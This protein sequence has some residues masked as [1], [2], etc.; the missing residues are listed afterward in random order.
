M[1]FDKFG[2]PIR[3]G[4]SKSEGLPIELAEGVAS[5]VIG[6][7]QGIGELGASAVDL[8]AGSNYSSAITDAAEELRE[9]LGIDPVG[10]AGKGAE[11]LTQFVVPGVAAAR[12]VGAATKAARK[13][14][15]L[16]EDLKDFTA[17]EKF[18]YYAKELGAAAGVDAAVSTDGMT[19]IGDFFGGGPTASDQTIGLDGRAEA[20]RRIKNK[21]KIGAE[22]GVVGGVLTG[23]VVG[24]KGA[25]GSTKIQEKLKQLEQDRIFG[26]G[27]DRELT[28]GQK[29]FADVL[30]GF[31]Y[32]S[33]LPEA[34]SNKRLMTSGIVQNDVMVA[35]NLLNKFDKNLSSA[36]NNLSG[37]PLK[38][39]RVQELN[40]IMDY[41][42]SAPTKDELDKGITKE[43]FKRS[44]LK[45][46]N[47]KLRKDANDMR[48][49]ID[50]LSDNILNSHFLKY[51]DFTNTKTGK[52]QLEE[53]ITANLN[54]YVRRRYRAL[55]NANYVPDEAT[56]KVVDTFFK[57]KEGKRFAAQMFTKARGNP[58]IP[59]GNY[60]SDQKMKD[61]GLVEVDNE[62]RFAGDVSDE[63]AAEARKLTLNKYKN[64]KNRKH[65]G[66]RVA[67]DRLNTGMFIDRENIPPAIRQLLGEVDDPREA[68]LG[69][70]ADLSEFKAIDDYF[71]VTREL[72]DANPETIGKYF[73]NP[74]RFSEDQ[75]KSLVDSGNY[76]QLGSKNGKSHIDRGDDVAVDEPIDQSGWGA[77]HG[78]IVP[79]SIYSNLT[80]SVL[81]EDNVVSAGVSRLYGAFLRAKGAS[82]YSKTVLSPITQI[83]NFTTASLFA[84]AN[85]NIGSGMG[86]SLANSIDAV[87]QN[88]RGNF[89]DEKVLDYLQDAQSRGVLGT[90]AELREIQ[91]LISQGAGIGADFKPAKTGGA[92][93]VQD[94]PFAGEKL[95]T[96]L[97]KSK[98]AQGGGKVFK[99]MEKAYQG[100]DDIWKLHSY[101]FEQKRLINS[102]RAATDEQKFFHLTKNGTDMSLEAY[103]KWAKNGGRIDDGRVTNLK[104]EIIDELIKDRAAQ[105]VRD[106]VPNYNKAPD[107]LK[108]ARKVPVGNFITF[109]Y[110]IWRTSSHI[111]KQALEDI[112][113][114][115]KEVQDEGRKRLI[116][117]IGTTAVLPGALSTFAY[118]VSGVD[119]D[120][121]KA[122]QRSFGATWEKNSLLIPLS[123]AKDG[124]LSYIN[125]SLSNPYD[126]VSRMG[127]AALNAIETGA[128][129]NQSVPDIMGNIMFQSTRE[130]AEPFLSQSMVAEALLDVTAREG[131]TQTGAEIF[132]PQD[133]RFNKMAK[134]HLHVLDTILP[135]LIPLEVSGGELQ[136]SRFARAG[137]G[138]FGVVSD[139][140]KFGRER[141]IG[142]T[143]EKFFADGELFRLTGFSSREFNIKK[144]TQ[145]K[146][147]EHQR[148]Q[149]DS[150][151]LFNRYT[152]DEN[153]N[154]NTFVEGYQYGNERKFAN[155][156]KF[157]QAIQDLKTLGLSEPEIKKIL[158]QNAM[159]TG[160]VKEIFKGKFTPFN[161]TDDNIR[162]MKQA[163]TYDIFPTS[164]IN[165]MSNTFK[166][167][168]YEDVSSTPTRTQS[169][170]AAGAL[171]SLVE[172]IQNIVPPAA[173]ATTTPGVRPQFTTPQSN[174]DPQSLAGS[175]LA[176]Q[177]IARR[178]SPS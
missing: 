158:K 85:G 26:Q 173:A 82:Q 117:F 136:L 3:T 154:A 74:E 123:I 172:N 174:I 149:R 69:T 170:G 88:I 16:S 132:N 133:T 148:A 146:G 71:G 115:I 30:A 12:T 140:D 169:P 29:L 58:D 53:T 102:L 46:I 28:K 6:I 21:L 34:I 101:E 155:D 37:E 24:A 45:D 17:A 42:T 55:E 91:D 159:L 176:T 157:Y 27:T 161:I 60:L 57:T 89:T 35:E 141:S 103:Q 47:P 5:G 118:S 150:R 1:A 9:S 61:L 7:G 99:F 139:T 78:Y 145:F 14:K 105:I 131:R 51:N 67:V 138:S 2:R 112:R 81:N 18:G 54:T 109:P 129:L 36:F 11:V 87:R 104:P 100:S 93:L 73:M 10:F 164:I 43:I 156:K 70:I 63:A 13:A 153:A 113:S 168:S 95:G 19:T 175:N 166:N 165:E 15:G 38:N 178:Q 152:D 124:N 65:K 40:K 79:E 80:R 126:T 84:V 72:A 8:V 64:L 39:R 62:I 111:I 177:E 75:I 125:F 144:G 23:A 108:A 134:A 31:R 96:L 127:Y 68:Y 97:E 128:T 121:M 171:S 32:R 48:N 163:G 106:T 56:E 25:V 94:I 20:L 114:P 119:R 83:R 160:D 22:A 44:K 4:K 92:A 41:L 151:R 110:E 59:G 135:N 107:V 50:K 33:F 130:L 142:G 120:Q 66:G 77:L 86:G 137:L 122:Y 167:L 90:Q 116:S 76:V 143:Q 52:K 49:H 98:L 162:K 147:R